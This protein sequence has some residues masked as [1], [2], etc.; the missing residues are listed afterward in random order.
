LCRSAIPA[1]FAARPFGRAKPDTFAI[2]LPSA[3]RLMAAAP[4]REMDRHMICLSPI[5][6]L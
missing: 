6:K 1:I 4:L 2:G 5:I 3:R